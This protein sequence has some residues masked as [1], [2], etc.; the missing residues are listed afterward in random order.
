[1]HIYY[2]D[3]L[4]VGL[5]VRIQKAKMWKYNEV[6]FSAAISDR[7]LI[8]FVKI[9]LNNDNL[10]YKY[11]VRLLIVYAA[12]NFRDFFIKIYFFFCFLKSLNICSITHIVHL[13]TLIF[14]YFFISF[15]WTFCYFKT[16]SLLMAV[17]VL[18][19]FG[20]T[21]LYSKM[22]EK[23]QVSFLNVSIKSLN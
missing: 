17:V 21:L 22:D 20:V 15:F 5:L 18:V 14:V 7:S 23:S 9:Y 6:N 12:Y 11:F 1:M 4:Y 3:I 19:F 13:Y 2:M 8:F 10:F 16:A